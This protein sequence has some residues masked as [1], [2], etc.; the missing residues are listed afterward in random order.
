MRKVVIVGGL[1][2][3]FV[4]ANKEFAATH[5]VDLAAKNIKEFLFR[6]SLKAKEIDE[7]ILGNVANLPET[8][9]IARVA[10][11]K[12]GFPNSISACDSSPQLRLLFGK[13]HSGH[14]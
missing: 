4:K 12:A 7:V 2:T 11:L 8:A 13:P 1:R 5:P 9:N 10:A 6:S 3:P 14:S